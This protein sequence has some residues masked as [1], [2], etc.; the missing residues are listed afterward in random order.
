MM[1]DGDLALLLG[2]LLAGGAGAA[3]GVS[4][5]LR[6]G[7]AVIRRTGQKKVAGDGGMMVT[8]EQW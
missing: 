8:S 6:Q 5:S 1:V 3:T 7:K 4:L 2:G